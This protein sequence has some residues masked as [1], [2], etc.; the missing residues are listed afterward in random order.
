VPALEIG[1]THAAAAL[2]DVE[3]GR[4]VGDTTQRLPLTAS[5]PAEEIIDTVARCASAIGAGSGATWGV[6][7]PGPFDYARGIGRFQGVGKFESLNGVDVERALSLA[8]RPRPSRLL[9][10][11][12]GDAFLLGEWAVGAAAEH[13]RAVALTLGTGV[14]S[15]FLDGG[16]IVD[17]RADVPPEGRVDLLEIAGRPLEETVS[18]RAILAQ[19]AHRQDGVSAPAEDVRHVAQRALEGEAAARAVFDNAFESLGRVLAPWLVRFE[20]TILVV[21]GAMANSWELVEGPLRGGL[22]AAEPTL[23]GRTLVVRGR[24]GAEAALYGA[25]HAVA[26]SLT[27]PRSS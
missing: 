23:R 9:F 1:G 7:V 11:N 14:G 15:A 22:C 18:R 5:A 2:V 12:D 3:A 13:D 24:L 25:A 4:I 27:V 10:L 17:S 21:G 19:Y 26:V 16:A 20:A 8:I 6:A